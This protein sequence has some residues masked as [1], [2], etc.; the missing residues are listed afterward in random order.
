MMMMIMIT[1]IIIIII[2]TWPMIYHPSN[3]AAFLLTIQNIPIL[4]CN[5]QL[6]RS[7]GGSFLLSRNRQSRLG[8][9]RGHWE[10]GKSQ[11][12]LCSRNAKSRSIECRNHD[13]FVRTSAQRREE[14]NKAWARRSM[15]NPC[16]ILV[17]VCGEGRGG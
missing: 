11:K 1:I 8:G 10:P 15:Y 9:G 16:I 5:E 17:L 2:P 4:S 6:L 12:R 7:S 14:L 3:Q 13:L